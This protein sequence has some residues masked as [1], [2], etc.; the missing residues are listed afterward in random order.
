MSDDQPNKSKQEIKADL[1][2][3]KAREKAMRPWFK[4]KRFVVPIVIVILAVGSS[5][6]SK[7]SKSTTSSDSTA[8]DTSSSSKS[9]DSGSS[10][11]ENKMA[12]LGEKVVDGKFTFTVGSVKCGVSQI[13]ND[14]FGKT[15]QGQYC[16]ISVSVANTG[17]E[18]QTMFA[19]NQTVFDA[20]GRKFSADTEAMIYLPEKDSPWLTDINPGN[21]ISGVLLFDVPKD[22]T[23]D[24]IELHDSAYSMG[25]EVSLVK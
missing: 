13:G 22:V 5:M 2:A 8:T 10:A 7:D 15:A 17:D 20:Q 24:H 11:A 25:V 1:K 6:A 9:T 23:L 12:T 19:D 18:A 16:L 14:T 21:S 3:A 4:K